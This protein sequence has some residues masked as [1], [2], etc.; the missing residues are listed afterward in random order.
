MTATVYPATLLMTPQAVWPERSTLHVIVM[1]A[2]VIVA[3][4][5]LPS[6]VDKPG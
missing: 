1:P 4:A 5:C 2:R 6:R 3:A